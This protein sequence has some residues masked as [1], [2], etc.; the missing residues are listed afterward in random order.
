MFFVADV[1]MLGAGTF[2]GLCFVFCG[3]AALCQLVS[4]STAVW[5]LLTSVHTWIAI[6]QLFFVRRRHA[7]SSLTMPSSS[8]VEDLFA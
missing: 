8:R 5:W 7:I 3:C 1:T 4:F 2:R 6:L